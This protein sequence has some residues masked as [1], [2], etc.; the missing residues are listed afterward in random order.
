MRLELYSHYLDAKASDRPQDVQEE[1]TTAL[2]ACRQRLAKTAALAI[3]GRYDEG[4]SLEVLADR[5]QRS[6]A[7]T[8]QLLYRARLALRDC[9]ESQLAAQG[10]E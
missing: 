5:L 6:V 7:A 10:G 8:T 4:L 2:A 3:Q 9:I 1:L